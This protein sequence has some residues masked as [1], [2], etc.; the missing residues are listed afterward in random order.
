MAS[1]ITALMASIAHFAPMLRD[2]A[3]AWPVV[4]QPPAEAE[5]LDGELTDILRLSDLYPDTRSRS[6]RGAFRQRSNRLTAGGRQ[7]CPRFS[8]SVRAIRASEFRAAVIS[9]SSRKSH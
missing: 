6:V 5:V 2:L 3:L 1:K 4:W 9:C 7:P 8:A